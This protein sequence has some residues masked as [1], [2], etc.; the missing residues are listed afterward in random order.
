MKRSPIKRTAMKRTGK[1]RISRLAASARGR[2]CQVRLPGVCTDD[3]ETAVLAHLP[4]GG[5]GAKRHDIHAAYCCYAC[6]MVLDG[7]ESSDFTWEELRLYHYEGCIRTEEIIL[8]EGLI[9][10]P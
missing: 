1:K 9:E 10:C 8:D 2:G 6:H 7:H 3:P 4:G 5:M